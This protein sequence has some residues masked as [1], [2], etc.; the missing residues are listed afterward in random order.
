MFADPQVHHRGLVQYAIFGHL[1]VS[2]LTMKE[3]RQ[4]RI[5][6]PPRVLLHRLFAAG[7]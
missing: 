5:V 1:G 6:I 7:G 4:G 3:L 2:D